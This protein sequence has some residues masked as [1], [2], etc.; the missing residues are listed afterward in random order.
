[1]LFKFN[2]EHDKK[3]SCSN[4][5]YDRDWQEDELLDHAG[6]PGDLLLRALRMF[7]FDVFIPLAPF[8]APGKLSREDEQRWSIEDTRAI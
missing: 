1:V 8:R 2:S 4:H 5:G 6:L 7:P 3:H